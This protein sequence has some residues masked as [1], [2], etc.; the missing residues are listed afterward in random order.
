M[1]EKL[2]IVTG[3]PLKFSQL[4]HELGNYFN[5]EQGMFE[6]YAE[7]QGT[8]EEIIT[9]K[10]EAAYSHFKE[11]VLVDDTSLHFDELGGFPGPYIKDFITHLPVYDMGVKFS[12]TRVKIVSRLG[13]YNGK[14]DC[15][16]ANGAVNGSVVMPKNIDPGVRQ[17]ELFVQ[18]DGMDRPM[19]EYDRHEINEYSHRGLAMKDLLS[20]L[21]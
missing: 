5:C 14:D 20:K 12:G 3:N 7:I 16:I 17:F 8:P 15:I 4:A 11:P 9:H 10:L 19:I 1:K 13:F 6:G 2:I 18:L 21:N